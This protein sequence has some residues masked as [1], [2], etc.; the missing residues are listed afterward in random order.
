MSRPSKLEASSLLHARARAFV[1]AFE[2]AETMPEAFDGLACDIARFQ[3]E[4]VAGFAR[5]VRSR[6]LDPSTW[7]RAE[8]IP[9]VPTD[10]FKHARVSAFPESETPIIFRT[11]GTTIGARGAHPFRTTESYDAGALAFGRAALTKGA[12]SP[13]GGHEA[14]EISK[15]VVLGPSPKELPDSSLTHM[16]DLFARTLAKSY[17]ASTTYFME[18]GIFDIARLDEVIAR[19]LVAQA[20]PLLVLGT[21]F[22]MV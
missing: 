1:T 18:D 16:I 9:A 4:N 21:S 14:R 3:A 15:V 13:V 6:N 20:G 7:T 2:A 8:E 17:E 22:A 10:A 5:L 12:D 11:S 19:N